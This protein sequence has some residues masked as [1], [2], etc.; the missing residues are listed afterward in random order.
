MYNLFYEHT[1]RIAKEAEEVARIQQSDVQR[2]DSNNSF[3]VG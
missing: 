3:F 2:S 1:A